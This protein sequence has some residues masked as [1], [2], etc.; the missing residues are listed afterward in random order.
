MLQISIKSIRSPAASCQLAPS[1]Q[2]ATADLIAQKSTTSSNGFG[3]KANAPELSQS[4]RDF[5]VSHALTTITGILRGRVARS[6]SNSS[7][8]IP[9]IFRSRTI[10]SRA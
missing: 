1:A 2:S 8:S 5:G 10:Q 4:M 3:T 6:R 9:G 7:P